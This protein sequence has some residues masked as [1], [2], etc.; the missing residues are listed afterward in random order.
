MNNK[1][2]ACNIIASVE[3]SNC[4]KNT[5]QFWYYAYFLFK[6]YSKILAYCNYLG[7]YFRCISGS[8]NIFVKNI[9]D[10]PTL[11]AQHI[12]QESWRFSYRVLSALQ[13][14]NILMYSCIVDHSL[15]RRFL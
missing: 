7:L 14:F 4:F 13:V 15:Y 5:F 2:D 3:S 11:N 6:T 9:T 10:K 1:V 8:Y 12:Q